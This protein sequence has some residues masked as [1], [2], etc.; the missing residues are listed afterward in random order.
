MPLI[1]IGLPAFLGFTAFFVWRKNYPQAL[2]FSGLS[3][4]A[5]TSLILSFKIR[6]LKKLTLLKQIGAILTFGLL[7]GSILTGLLSDDI[8]IAYPWIFFFPMTTV[9]FF[10]SRTGIVAAAV[11]CFAAVFLLPFLEYP[12][13]NAPFQQTFKLNTVLSLTV[14]LIIALVSENSR[15]RMRNHLLEARNNYR[16]AEELQRRTNMELKSEIEMRLESEKALAQSE[17]RYR[18]LFEESAVSL[19]EENWSE[20]K[21]RLD[22]LS[23]RAGPDLEGYLKAHADEV[24]QLTMSVR[25]QAVNRATLALYEAGSIAALLRNIWTVLPPDVNAFMTKRILTIYRCGRYSDQVAVQTLGGRRLHLL[26][27][28]AVPAGYEQSW[29]KVYTSAYDI[30]ER[31]AVEEDKKRVDRQL[32]HT[33]Q[34]QAIASLAGGIAHQFNNSLAVICGNLDLLALDPQGPGCD[35]RFMGSLRSSTE[36]MRALT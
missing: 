19:W 28:S 11:F 32:H 21:V 26:L 34:I 9:L 23:H 15:V 10:S 17:K 31:V 29:E 22:E 6:D 2:F 3:L 14:I 4:T 33:R 12:A 5:A 1:L 13:W 25:I 35:N 16:Q 36:R 7:G 18:A 24:E 8:Y 30:T 27:G 20:V